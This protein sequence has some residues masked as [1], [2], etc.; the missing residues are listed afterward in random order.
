[1]GFKKEASVLE[2]IEHLVK[3]ETEF[4]ILLKHFNKLNKP[5]PKIIQEVKQFIKDLSS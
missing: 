4:N 2:K 1:M 3:N 5:Y